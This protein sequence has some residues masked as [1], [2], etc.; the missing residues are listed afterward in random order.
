MDVAPYL[1]GPALRCVVAQRLVPQ[2]CSQ[3]EEEYTPDPGVLRAFGVEP[4]GDDRFVRG[5]GCETCRDKGTIGR[6][7]LHEVL[8]VDA[9]VGRAISSRATESELERCARDA[10][11]RP[12]MQDG[13]EKA[14]LGLVTLE[15]VLAVARA[16]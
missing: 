9:A 15:S 11:F 16:S 5:R 12:M 14:R 2:V 3:C 8:Y 10:A 4:R 13:L 7:A 6:V 1:L